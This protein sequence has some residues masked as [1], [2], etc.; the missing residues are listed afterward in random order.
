MKNKP[1]L[2]AIAALCALSFAGCNNTLRQDTANQPRQN[3]LSPSDFFADGRSERPVGEN[4]A[5]RGPIQA[6]S[7][8]APKESNAFPLP[9]TP[10]LLQRRGQRSGSSRPPSHPIQG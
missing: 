8:L 4:T 6:D 9:L 2:F 1:S 10:A 5:V 7:L 3:P